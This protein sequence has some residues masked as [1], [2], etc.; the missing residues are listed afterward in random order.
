MY[1]TRGMVR[2]SKYS[3]KERNE[4]VIDDYNLLNNFKTI[5]KDKRFIVW[6]AGEKGKELGKNIYEYTRRVEFVD[7]DRAKQGEYCGI[8]IGSPEKMIDYVGDYAIVLSTDNL[9][10]QKSIL[11]QIEALNL[12]TVDIYTWHAMRTVLMFIKNDTNIITDQSDNEKKMDE[13]EKLTNWVSYRQIMQEQ[14]FMAEMAAKSVFVYQSKKV[15]SVSIVRSLKNAGVYGVHVHDFQFSQADAF[16]LRDMIRKTSGKV[17]SIV[18]EPVSRQISFLW[19]R[20]GKAGDDFFTENRYKSLEEIENQ[21]FAIPNVDD[22]FEWYLKEFK[23]ILD[24]NVYEYPFDKEKGYTIIENN[25]ITLLLLKTEKLND[26]EAVIGEFS[27]VENFR[28]SGRNMAE[29]KSYKFAYENYM[30]NVKIPLKFW[31]HYYCDNEYMDHFYTEKEKEIFYQ[32][33]KPH[34]C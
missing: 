25:G 24:I 17:I 30:E 13:L 32:R 23:D 5:F 19:H 11:E 14:M 21:Y 12:H 27:G 22:E 8:P 26:L 9:K 4:K 18:R 16:F 3:I 6:G 15:G 2:S 28:L 10:V 34:L 7:T 1:F 33:W 31:E 29:K 20:W